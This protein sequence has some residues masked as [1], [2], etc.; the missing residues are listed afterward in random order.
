MLREEDHAEDI[1]SPVA[2]W[3]GIRLFLALTTL[4]NLTPLQLDINLAYL[5]APLEEDIYMHP[6]R[7][8]TTPH[9]VYWKLEKSLYGLK[10]SGKN[11]HKMFTNVLQGQG[12]DFTQLGTEECLFT[13]L[14]GDEITILFIYVDDVYIASNHTDTLDAFHKELSKHFDLKILGIPRQLLGV[15]LQWGPNFNAVHL[16]ASKLIKELIE[17][18]KLTFA[19]YADTPMDPDYKPKK[20]DCPTLEERSTRQMKALQL[21]YQQIVGSF[22]FI[23]NTCR[24]DICYA[25]NKLC[26]R[27]SNP[28]DKDLAAAKHLASYLAGTITMGIGYRKS[29]NTTP[30]FYADS[31]DASDETR[32]SCAG[33]MSMLADGP[34][35]WK[36]G[37]IDS[38]SLSSCESEIR[39]INMAL[40]PIKES[41]KLKQLMTDIEETLHT[42]QQDVSTEQ[43]YSLLTDVP[44]EILEDNKACIDWSKHRTNSTKMR[45]LERSLKWIQTYV[46]EGKIRLIHIPTENQLADIFT[47]ALAKAPFLHLRNRFLFNFAYPE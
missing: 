31:D 25:T 7:G 33:Y 29:G 14:D 44:V 23:S 5:N 42:S 18:H 15:Q 21:Q 3:T 40:E 12:F 24:P 11:W 10:Q 32:K 27:M 6:P 8:S 37:M 16:S 19:K 9:G 2:S 38:L 22:I 34:I 28:D 1:S 43:A 41:V 46:A 4:Y 13:R 17:E 39:A 36:S 35:Y 45:H 47:K 20:S 26:R 30:Y